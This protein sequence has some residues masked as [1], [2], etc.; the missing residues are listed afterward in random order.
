MVIVEKGIKRRAIGRRPKER[1]L[2]KIVIFAHKTSGERGRQ[3]MESLSACQVPQSLMRLQTVNALKSHLK[4]SGEAPG[5]QVLVLLAETRRRLE[6]LRE[7]EDLLED[8]RLILVVPDGEAT[9]LSMAQKLYPRF[10]TPLA[11]RYDDL[12]AVIDRMMAK[13]SQPESG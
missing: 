6:A 5:G 4:K 9:T 11:D 7:L 10:F 2:V 1:R 3:L 13:A 8:S 12:C